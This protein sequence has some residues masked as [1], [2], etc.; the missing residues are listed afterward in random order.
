MLLNF[1]LVMTFCVETE[2]IQDLFIEKSHLSE[3]IERLLALLTRFYMC[4]LVSMSE[5]HF[6]ISEIEFRAHLEP[7]NVTNVQAL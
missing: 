1:L 6:N 7:K 5:K 3:T 4:P 2:K